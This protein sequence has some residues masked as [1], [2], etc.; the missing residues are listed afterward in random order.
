MLR[1][2]PGAGP[3]ILVA[4]DDD[5]LSEVVGRLLEAQGYRVSRAPRGLFPFD[6]STGFN[7]VILDAN[8]PGADFA[9]TLRF[10]RENN[11]AILVVS[12]EFAPPG[13][14]DEREF[15][16]KPVELDQLLAAVRRLATSSAA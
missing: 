12:G 14:V 6:G 5:L 3:R 4:D 7:L 11:I 9:A 8:I 16:A 1:Q 10:L 2:S 15:L 13:G